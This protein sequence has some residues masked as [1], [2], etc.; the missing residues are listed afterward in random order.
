M[1]IDSIFKAYD[2]RGKVGT[3]LTNDIVVKIAKAVADWLPKEGPVAVGRDMRSDSD[4]LAKAAIKG[5]VSQGR[6][7]WDIG[8][9][10]SDMIYFAVGKYKLAG[11][12]MITASHN[13]GEYN[14]IKFCREEAKPIGL[15]TGLS[16]IR[17]KVKTNKFKNKTNKGRVISRDVTE[18]WITHVLSFVD[19][20]DLKP[21]K[22]AVDAG[23][24]MVGKIFP[25]LEPYAPFDVIEMYFELD[26]GFP[27]HPANPIESKN[28]QD[29]I[30][31]VKQQKCDAGLAFDGDGD[32]AVLIDEKGVPISGTVMTSILAEYFLGKAPCSTV[33][34][35]AIVGRVAKETIEKHG[36]KAIRTKVGHSII[37]NEMRLHNALFAGEHSHHYYFRNNFMADSGLIASMVALALL[38]KSGIKLS[39]LADKFRKYYSVEETNFEID[40]KDAAM[41]KIAKSFSDAKIDW[42]D[43][44]TLTFNDGWVNVRPSNTEPL[45]R[46]NAEADTPTILNNYVKKVT[47]IINN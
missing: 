43:G 16:D 23:N 19:M 17:E 24:G 2:V 10:T 8:M 1:I 44:L 9:V 38:C 21:L 42:L 33:L 5:L 11:G 35:N 14:G 3:E 34:Y 7:V 29:L 41:N 22:I 18:D 12:L 37:K 39:R 26:G 46:L 13:P 27:N 25:E 31:V 40:D 15:D 28:L 6:D 32:R 4:E 30:N 47:K 36:G 20:G 45:L